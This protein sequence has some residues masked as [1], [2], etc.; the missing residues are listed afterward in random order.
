[1][2]NS[3]ENVY[4]LLLSFRQ[5]TLTC[6][7]FITFSFKTI[8]HFKHNNGSGKCPELTCPPNNCPISGRLR[9]PNNCETCNCKDPCAELACPEETE[10]I[11]AYDSGQ[12]SIHMC[13]GLHE[14]A[15]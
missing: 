9:N 10:C 6:F 2:K 15:A 5:P 4:L 3:S 7:M 1:M 12:G 13:F 14:A 11:T 8:Q